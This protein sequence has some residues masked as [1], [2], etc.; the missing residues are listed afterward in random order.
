VNRIWSCVSQRIALSVGLLLS[1]SLAP[2]AL[3]AE[4]IEVIVEVAKLLALDGEDFDEFGHSVSLDGDRL[5]ISAVEGGGNVSGT[6]V[7]YV[8]ERDTDGS[9]FQVSKLLALDGEVS[10]R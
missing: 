7:A 5:A 6:G 1:L 2:V 3:A 9:W 8:F 4:E 10:G